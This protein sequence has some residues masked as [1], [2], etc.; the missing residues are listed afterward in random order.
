MVQ[1]GGAG[2]TEVIGA[3]YKTLVKQVTVRA[4]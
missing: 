1:G 2:S 3:R 4:R